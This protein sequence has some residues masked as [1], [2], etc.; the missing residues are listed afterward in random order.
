MYTEEIN[1][2]KAIIWKKIFVI[3]WEE[4][5]RASESRAEWPDGKI[6]YSIIGLLQQQNFAQDR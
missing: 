6:I 5:E 1:F 3:K 2:F 4:E